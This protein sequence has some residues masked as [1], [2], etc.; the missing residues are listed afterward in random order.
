VRI[1][2]FSPLFVRSQK[3]V[4]DKEKHSIILI[5]GAQGEKQIHFI[6][7]GQEPSDRVL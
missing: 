6:R 1:K 7:A 2:E 3:K 5:S 4:C